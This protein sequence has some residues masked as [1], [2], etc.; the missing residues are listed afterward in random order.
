MV[1]AALDIDAFHRPALGVVKVPAHPLVLVGVRF[2][3]DGVVNNQHAILP[4][5]FTHRLFDVL[6]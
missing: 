2:F 1:K 6:P 5:H 3:L 4:F